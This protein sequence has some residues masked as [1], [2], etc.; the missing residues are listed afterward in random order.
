MKSDASTFW[1]I[2]GSQVKVWRDPSADATD[3]IGLDTT[4]GTRL[5]TPE[6]ARSI[7]AELVR[8]ADEIEGV[9]PKPASKIGN[10][11]INVSPDLSG[12]SE[13]IAV[14]LETL[15]ERLR[16]GGPA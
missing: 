4:G 9:Q 6:V 12:F 1:S 15:V 7:A 3:D 14:E 11:V 16:G 13:A 2:Y 5:V 8:L 10:V